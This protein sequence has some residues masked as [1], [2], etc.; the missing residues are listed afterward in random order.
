[1]NQNTNTLAKA[2]AESVNLNRLPVPEPNGF[3]GDP[4]HYIEW[5]T[6]FEM[7]IERKGIPPQ[8]KIFY[9]KKYIGGAARKALDGFFYSSSQLAYENARKILDERY[10]HPFIMQKAFRDKVDRWTKIDSTSSFSILNDCIENKKLLSKLPDWASL[11]WNRQV[12]KALDETGSYIS[13]KQFVEF[14]VSEA[15]V[16][17]NPISSLYALEPKA[18]N[19]EGFS[20]YCIQS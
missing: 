18:P 5:K 16:A 6:S 7:F 19:R 12:T 15:R 3:T 11:R 8:E 13:F 10:G 1:M 17:C 20:Y 2:L 9:L 4:L 14:K